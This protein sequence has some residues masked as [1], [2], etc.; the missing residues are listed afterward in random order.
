MISALSDAKQVHLAA[1]TQRMDYILEQHNMATV[2][3]LLLLGV[4][5]QRSPYGAGAWAQIRYAMSMCIEMGLHRR[6]PKSATPSDAEDVE[7]KRRA[8]WC[9]YSL[10]RATSQV[11]GRPFAIDERDINVEVYLRTWS[12]IDCC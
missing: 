10:D 4:H 2:Q 1:A 12:N 8:F 5:G 11:L 6:R 7:L 3:F 9:C